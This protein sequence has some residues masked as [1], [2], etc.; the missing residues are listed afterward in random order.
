MVGYWIPG[1]LTNTVFM[2]AQNNDLRLGPKRI[3]IFIAFDRQNTH[4]RNGF[5]GAFLVKCPIFAQSDFA[6][7]VEALDAAHI[8]GMAFGAPFS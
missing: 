3:E 5:W 8:I 4:H 1:Y 2:V 7:C 6:V